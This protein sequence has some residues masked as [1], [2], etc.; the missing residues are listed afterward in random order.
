M[1]LKTSLRG[2][3][4]KKLNPNNYVNFC[5]IGCQ[6]NSLLHLVRTKTSE[7]LLRGGDKVF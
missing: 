3:K 4:K 6:G 5:V 1:N 7:G 2:F